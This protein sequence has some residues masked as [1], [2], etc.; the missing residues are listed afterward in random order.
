MLNRMHINFEN[1]MYEKVLSIIIIIKCYIYKFVYRICYILC[2]VA[3]DMFNILHANE[4]MYIYG[5]W[6]VIL[7]QEK[8]KKRKIKKRYVETKKQYFC[9]SLFRSSQ[10]LSI[11]LYFIFFFSL[12][13]LF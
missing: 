10:Y 12:S 5:R 1:K 8:K 13:I 3:N 7:L 2:E 6:I 4:V 11:Y 9:I